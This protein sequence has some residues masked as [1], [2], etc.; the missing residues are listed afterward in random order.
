MLLYWTTVIKVLFTGRWIVICAIHRWIVLF[1]QIEWN[2]GNSIFY[3]NTIYIEQSMRNIIICSS[4]CLYVLSSMLWFPLRFPYKNYVRFVFTSNFVYE[5]SCLI[6][7]IC[8]CLRLVVSN[9]YCYMS[10]MAGALYE[11]ATAYSWRAHVFTTDVLVLSVL[12]IFLVFCDI[13]L[14][15]PMLP[16]SLV[17]PFFIAPSVSS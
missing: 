7:V 15:Y 17:C 3:S 12:L 11:V 14:V 5:G 9:T 2:Y 8:V 16:V 1:R 6:G 13:C 10:N 4:M